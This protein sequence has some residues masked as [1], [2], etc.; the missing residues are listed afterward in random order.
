MPGTKI[1]KID[2]KSPDRNEIKFAA[3]L[4]RD[5]GLVAFPTETVY[6]IG[7]NYEDAKALNRLYEVKKRDPKKPFTLHISSLDMMESMK[8][9][10]SDFAKKL[11]KKF[12][13]G[14]LTL[15]LPCKP[16]GR[17]AVGFRMPKNTVAKE[18]IAECGKPLCVPSA[19][20][21]GCEA[22]VEAA[23]VVKDF[24]EKI[25]LILDGGKTEVSKESTVLDLTRF[26]YR[27]LR[28]GAVSEEEIKRTFEEVS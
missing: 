19:N 23:S 7:A 13:P 1:I 12:W 27:I 28:K 20:M 26:P 16:A 17:P 9:E 10:I 21:S 3:N 8:C 5:G 24:N 6:G 25:D 2:P 4:L 18:L 14:P 22:P 11:I 15:I